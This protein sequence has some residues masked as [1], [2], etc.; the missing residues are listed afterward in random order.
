MTVVKDG[1]R[2]EFKRQLQDI[3]D[4]DKETQSNRLVAQL[5]E[6]LQKQSGVWTLFSPLNDEPNLLPLFSSC[7]HLDWV[8]PRVK[9]KTDMEF[10]KISSI[11]EMLASS[12]GLSEPPA[13]PDQSVDSDQITGCLI[14]GLAFDTFGTRLGRGGGFYDRFL[15]N[16]K[17]LKLGVTFNRGLTTETLPRKSHDQQMNIVISPDQWTEV[18]TSEV[19]YGI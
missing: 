7:G 12:W 6:F 11:D 3:S 18:N 14:P 15:V 19:R 17:G 9:N 4:G 5:H 13:N 1:L 10:F 2:V 16:F 8:F